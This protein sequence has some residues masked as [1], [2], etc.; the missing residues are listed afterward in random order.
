MTPSAIAVFVLA[1]LVVWGG[2]IASIVYLVL[3]GRSPLEDA[4][5]TAATAPT[6][7]DG[8]WTGPTDAPEPGA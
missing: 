8:A 3:H 2:L 4:D 6:A 5:D 1:G 7:D